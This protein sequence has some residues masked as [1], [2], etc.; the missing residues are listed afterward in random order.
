MSEV[1]SNQQVNLTIQPSTLYA[2]TPAGASLFVERLSAA[3]DKWLRKH[4]A[5]ALAHSVPVVVML[6]PTESRAE[7]CDVIALE[8]G[9]EAPLLHID[10]AIAALQMAR[11]ALVAAG[12]V[13]FIPELAS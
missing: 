6:D 8:Y 11:E 3:P 5:N 7:Y 4:G 1:S 10:Q 12:Q 9:D 13:D 2:S